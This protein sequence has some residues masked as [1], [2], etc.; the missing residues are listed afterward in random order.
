MAQAL[1]VKFGQQQLLIG[2]GAS[3]EVFTAPCGITS[4]T[5][6]TSTNTSDI[7]IPDCDDPDLVLWLGIDEVSR[8]MTLTF[9]G[10][11]AQQSLPLW[12]EWS[13]DGGFRNVRWFRN[14]DDLAL[15]G[16]LAGPALL[17][18]FEET[19]E[20]RGRYTFSGTIIFDG[21]PT[22]T[23][24]PAAPTNTV[25]PSFTGTLEVSETQTSAD[26]TWT[27][28]PTFEYQWERSDN[29]STAWTS[30][31]GATSATYVAD[32]ADEG[33]FLRVKVTGTNAGGSAIA[34]SA[35]RGPVA[36]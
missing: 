10:T 28:S 31:S 1:T 12:D 6:S 9:S 32:A 30:I 8:R 22:W 29:G 23:S 34:Y 35:S 14:L 2:D 19:S 36:P 20:A 26:G 5:K 24:L 15:R 18:E 33:K 27:G 11:I 7:D 17:T 16:Y 21:K 25:A 13:L 4:L 3:P